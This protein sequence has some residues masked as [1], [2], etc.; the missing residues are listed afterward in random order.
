MTTE[1]K[2]EMIPREPTV[3]PSRQERVR[4]F[5]LKAST[6][7]KRRMQMWA[8]QRIS[9]AQDRDLISIRDE[10]VKHGNLFFGGIIEETR[11]VRIQNTK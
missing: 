1:E 8:Y 7:M 4:E 2:Q 5:R 10:A 3:K 11:Q 6:M 9:S